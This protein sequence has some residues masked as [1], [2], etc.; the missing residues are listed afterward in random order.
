M[1]STKTKALITLC[2]LKVDEKVI[3]HKK[4]HLFIIKNGGRN[5]MKM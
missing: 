3:Q 1:H 5:Q 4:C 2:K